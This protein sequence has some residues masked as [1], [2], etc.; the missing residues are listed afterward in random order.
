MNV[1]NKFNPNTNFFLH[2]SNSGF[3]NPNFFI[4]VKK[5]FGASHK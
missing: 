4:N 3:L 2:F 1:H 5:K